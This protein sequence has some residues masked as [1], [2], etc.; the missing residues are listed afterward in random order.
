MYTVGL[1]LMQTSLFFSCPV[2]TLDRILKSHD[3]PV[4][5]PTGHWTTHTGKPKQST[6]RAA[7]LCMDSL[8][9]G[10]RIGLFRGAKNYDWELE[11]GTQ[12]T[13]RGWIF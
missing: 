8:I 12:I 10:R 1:R 4:T 3:K 5:F 13:P 11:L 7:E 2:K 6:M 9:D